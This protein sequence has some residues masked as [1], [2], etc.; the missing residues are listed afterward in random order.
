MTLLNTIANLGGN[1]P[2]TLALWFV[3]DLDWTPPGWLCGASASATEAAASATSTCPTIDGYYVQSVVC[4]GLGFLW[5]KLNRN[6]V[7]RLQNADLESWKIS[8]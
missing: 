7:Q 1:W 6:R 4:V 8:E 2:S 5:L 3:E